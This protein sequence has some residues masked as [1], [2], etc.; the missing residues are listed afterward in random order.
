MTVHNSNL[1]I[2]EYSDRFHDQVKEVI[3]KTLSDISVIDKNSLPI[4][5]PDLDKIS[6]IYCGKGRFWVA[7][8]DENV[9][10]TVAIKDLGDNIAKLNRMFV[11]I[12]YHGD[13]TGQKLLDHAINF[14]KKQ[15][16]KKIVL[17][18]HE[19]MNRAHSFY[20]R[21][22]FIKIGKNEDKFRYEKKLD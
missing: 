4:D 9:I 16:F 2:E 1:R 7:L 19:R 20:E 3:G 18:T 10:G 6:E 21:N 8:I 13:G 11:L 12:E 14:A 17:N 22:G 5:D 15:A